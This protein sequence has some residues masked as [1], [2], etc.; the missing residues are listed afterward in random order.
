MRRRRESLL[1]ASSLTFAAIA[2]SP[3][4][5]RRIGV[6]KEGLDSAVESAAP[7]AQGWR[8]LN[9]CSARRGDLSVHET[10]LSS[11]HLSLAS[12]PPRVIGDTLQIG[13]RRQVLL[14]PEG[15]CAG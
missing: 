8:R 7:E 12:V 13:R 14:F 6:F 10:L 2:A 1:S 15:V 5:Q 3:K 11:P 9:G 4:A